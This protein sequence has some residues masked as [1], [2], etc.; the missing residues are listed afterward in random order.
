M[1]KGKYHDWLTEDGLLR[2]RGWA[3]DGLTDEQIAYNMGIRRETLYDWKK[4]FPN[5]SKALKESKEIAD[6]NVEN[7][8]YKRALG[9]KYYEQ[10]VTNKGEVVDVEK[11]E[12][13]NTTAIIYWLKNRKRKTWKDKQEIEHSGDTGLN[14]QIDYGDEDDD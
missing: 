2:I 13:P 5:I 10:T 14:I 9:Y 11:Y 8:L 6:R 3:R 12:H 1:A 4:R 7:A